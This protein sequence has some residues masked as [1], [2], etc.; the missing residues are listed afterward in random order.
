[1]DKSYSESRLRHSSCVIPESRFTECS[2]NDAL[3]QTTGKFSQSSCC[4]TCYIQSELNVLVTDILAWLETTVLIQPRL[5]ECL[6]G[7]GHC[8]QCSGGSRLPV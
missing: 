3:V 1:M 2:L 8:A 5:P 7:T 4:A 6:S